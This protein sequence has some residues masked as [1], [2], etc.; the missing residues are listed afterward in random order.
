MW[1]YFYFPEGNPKIASAQYKSLYVHPST[2]AAD[3]DATAA[4]YVWKWAWAHSILWQNER[5]I[6]RFLVFLSDCPSIMNKPFAA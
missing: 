1:F 2:T 5:V 6:G 3:A 4:V